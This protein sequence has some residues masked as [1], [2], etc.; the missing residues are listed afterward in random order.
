M[1]S[2]KDNRIIIGYSG[3]DILILNEGISKLIKV[4]KE[5]LL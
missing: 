4:I 5:A 1:D 2:K 3:I